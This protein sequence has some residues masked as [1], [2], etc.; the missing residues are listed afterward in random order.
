MTVSE[1]AAYLKGL[2]DGLEIGK[3]TKEGKLFDAIIDLLSD[4]A[5]DLEDLGDAVIELGEEIDAVS[6]DLEDVEDFIFDEDDD[7]DDEDGCCCEDDDDEYDEDDEP[8][9]FSLK[10]PSC[11]NEITVDEDVL[12]LGSINCPNCNELLEFEFDDDE[13]E[14]GCGCHDKE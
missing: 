13:C 9:F 10:C 14:C 8:I 6:D 11:E 2:A 5:G 12:D 1:K 7:D 4:M 3:D